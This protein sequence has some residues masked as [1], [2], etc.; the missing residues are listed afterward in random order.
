MTHSA[1]NGNNSKSFPKKTKQCDRQKGKADQVSQPSFQFSLDVIRS[2][3]HK[4]SQCASS[5][6]SSLSAELS[7]RGHGESA[8]FLRIFAIAHW[9]VFL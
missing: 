9:A 1:I 7:V 3:R 8:S 6:E 5:R 4:Q 2:S